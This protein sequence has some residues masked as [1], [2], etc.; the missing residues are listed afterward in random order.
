MI[1]TN[2][3]VIQTA[4]IGDVILTTPMLYAFKHY[5]PKAK[6]AVMVKP[7]AAEIL[8]ELPVIDHVLV[9]E[10]RGAHR[11]VIGTLKIIDTIRQ[12]KFDLLLAP[13]RSHRTALLSIFSQIPRRCGY[14]KAGFSSLAYTHRMERDMNRP[15]IERLLQF[16]EDA[17]SCPALQFSRDLRIVV[18]DQARL[19]AQQI[20]LQLGI[21]SPIVIAPSSIW[22]TKRWTP[23]GFAFI[24]GKL[25]RRYNRDIVL[26]GS[27]EDREAVQKT[28]YFLRL[29]QPESLQ[30]RIFDLSGQTS[31]AGL[32]ALLE[33]SF[34]LISND[35]A[36]VHI[37]CAAKIPVVA[38]FGPT[39]PAFGY[40]PIT[41]N[42]TVAQIDLNCR[43]CG[44]HGHH[45]CPQKHFRCMKELS[46]AIVMEA[47]ER[48]L[49]VSNS[50]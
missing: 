2:A 44:L 5:F 1:V 39:V 47:V 6:L 35:S 31:L 36:P 28:L 16:L 38:I 50:S 49:A 48:V 8:R 7:Q 24:I 14:R 34:L 23:W 37:G 33:K 4:F 43:P 46:P 45:K 27:K 41:K 32:Y 18:N 15:E 17:T 25:I 22:P 40:A 12:M 30:E 9:I 13:H 29:F 20:F 3:L 42:S 19:E 26:I 11:G 10:K 21:K